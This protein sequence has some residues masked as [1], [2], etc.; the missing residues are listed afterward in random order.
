MSRWD[1]VDGL[2][3]H[4]RVSVE[5]VPLNRSPLVLVHGLSVSSRYMVPTAERFAP[6]IRVFAPDLPG[7]GKSDKPPS[8]LSIPELADA[9]VAWMDVVGIERAPMIANSLGCQV[10]VDFA[11]RYPAR[12][13][14]GVLIAP[15]MDRHARTGLQQIF[16]LMKDSVRE[17]LSQPFVVLSDYFRTGPVRTFKTL[18]YAL[19][20]PIELKLPGVQAPMLVIRGENDP[21]VPQQWAEE[22]TN[23][24]PDARLIVIPD[25]AHTINYSAP[26]KLLAV[27]RSF[28]GIDAEHL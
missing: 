5:P 18:H 10:V 19:N 27:T 28:L 9:L 20:D 24:M 6:L 12:L 13:E 3:I 2:R 15:T 7:F 21:I 22:C 26:D 23:L 25:E 11:L 16:R 17:P 14:R 8:V 4:T 1:R